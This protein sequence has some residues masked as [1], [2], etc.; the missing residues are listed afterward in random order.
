MI[1][2]KILNKYGKVRIIFA[3]ILVLFSINTY[4]TLAATLKL[5]PSNLGLVGYWPMDEGVGTV[6]KDLSGNKN[7]GT[8]TGGPTWVTG[9]LGG[10]LNLNGSSAY[11]NVG[12]SSVFNSQSITVNAWVKYNAF[13]GSDNEIVGKYA[14]SNGS[15]GWILFR[16]TASYENG[17]VT[18]K[19]CFLLTPPSTGFGLG[20]KMLVGAN[21]NLT[22]GTWYHVVGTYDYNSNVMSI[23]VNGVLNNSVTKSTTQG[24][25]T[26]TVNVSI[27]A[28]QLDNNRFTNGLIDD[29]RIYNRSLSASEVQQ[30]YSAGVAKMNTS[31]ANKNTSG[32]LR[33]WTFDGADTS[34]TTATDISGSGNNGTLV[35]SPS[36]VSGKIGQALNL[37]GSNQYITSASAF[38]AGQALTVTGWL[39]STESTAIYKNFLDTVSA[40]PM[41]WW[42]T[43]GKIEFDAGAGRSTNVYRNQWVFVALSKPSGSSNPTYYVNG[44]SIGSGSTYSVPAS[45]PTWFN[46]GG[47]QTW[48]GKADDI[49]TYNRALSASEIKQIY[50]AGVGTQVNS[51]QANSP[52]GSLTTGLVGY[53]SFNGIDVSTTTAFDRSGS[54]NN[55]TLNNGPT[56]AIG[57]MGQSMK[58][59]GNLNYISITNTSSLQPLSGNWSV[60]FWVY[61]LGAGSG[62]YPEVIGSRPWGTAADKGWA[63]SYSSSDNKVGAHYADG[64][65]GF[66]VTATKSSSTVALNTWQHWVVVFDRTNGKLNYY[67]NGQLDIQQSPTFPSGSINQTDTIYMG[68]EIA[69][70]NSRK[71][72]A[73]IDDVRVYNRALSL[74]EIKQL[75]LLGN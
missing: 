47:A 19:L 48:K 38:S 20:Q 70:A 40:S 35:N 54:S 75:Y 26:S 55:G 34:T 45:T 3:S 22:T 29:V 44:V 32:L 42:D 13:A 33:Y 10:A 2:P 72:N 66:D 57:K 7:N 16:S 46:R 58:F 50:N 28:N 68:R 23:Y 63:V 65:T 71:L 25:A 4:F 18:G 52:S 37:N 31:S 30:L 64:T 5:P 14:N 17:C 36:L 9:K 8:L 53:W 43:N 41:I 59:D 61:R 51:A 67:L 24:I 56:L 15:T 21:T 27:G 74:A 49:R 60:G 39:Y 73:K 12:N 6:T 62:D 69:G 1:F 11:I